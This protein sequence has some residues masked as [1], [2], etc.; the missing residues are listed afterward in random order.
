[1][2][3]FVFTRCTSSCPRLT[4]RMAE[5]EARVAGDKR[6]VRLVSFTVDPE[7][8]TPPVLADYAAR[9]GADLSRWSFVTGPVDDVMK[10]VVQGF[11]MS[12]ARVA[13]GAADYDVVHGDWFVLVDGRG[14]IRGYYATDEED[15]LVRVRSDAE[16]L[17]GAKD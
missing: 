10:V 17:E 11:K 16:R 8:D 4:R 1:V 15:G 9:A 2:V 5:L 12:A 7:N 13:K 6:D 3:D 14:R